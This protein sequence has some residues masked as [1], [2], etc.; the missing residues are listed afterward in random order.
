M[1]KTPCRRVSTASGSWA[2]GRKE[3]NQTVR[4]GLGKSQPHPEDAARCRGGTFAGH[5]LRALRR[6]WR[7]SFRAARE[8][9]LGVRLPGSLRPCPAAGFGDGSS[10]GWSSC[11]ERLINS[12]L[13]EDGDCFW[14][15]VVWGVV[16]G[17]AEPLPGVAVGP[18]RDSA[19]AR[20]GGSGGGVFALRAMGSRVFASQARSGRVPLPVLAMGRRGVGLGAKRG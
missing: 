6:L 14:W 10:R 12:G 5:G 20:S 8:G 16:S 2:I 11:R 13:V 1:S 19:Y 4:D 3:I 15:G 7:R 18:P 9:L 17:I